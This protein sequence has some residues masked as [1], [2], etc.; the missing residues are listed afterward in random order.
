MYPFFR[1]S[2]NIWVKE[3]DMDLIKIGKLI[4]QKRKAKNLTQSELAERL[5][6][7]DR[8]VSK[9]ECGRSLPDSSIMLELCEILGISVNE[10]LSGEELEMKTY[11]DQ[12]EEN[13]LAMLKQKE[14]SDRNL[15]K[16]EIVI[17]I[18]GSLFL[19]AMVIVGAYG[20][21]YLDLPLWATILM[22]VSGFFV[23]LGVISFCILIEQK[24]GYYECKECHHRYIPTYWQV[25]LA[26]HINRSR[27]MKCP[28]CG[29]RTYQKKVISKE[30]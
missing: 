15:L 1:T 17:G 30:E 24:A 11:N 16:A 14:D 25:F 29:K 19:F 9:W 22:I 8:A 12:A 7:T 3:E 13:L 23:F 20:R 10:L 6:V 28:H 5:S 2:F 4:Q 21:K 26:P 18:T 27:Y